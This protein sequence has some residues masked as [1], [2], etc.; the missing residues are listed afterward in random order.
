MK[1]TIE[2]DF[3]RLENL[4]YELLDP[5]AALAELANEPKYTPAPVAQLSTQD[6]DNFDTLNFAVPSATFT[7]QVAKPDNPANWNEEFRHLEAS[8][9]NGCIWSFD[10]D[11]SEE[12]CLQTYRNLFNSAVD[13]LNQQK[14]SKST[15]EILAEFDSWVG[16]PLDVL[17]PYGDIDFN[18]NIYEDSFE[19]SVPVRIISQNE[20]IIVKA[21][22]PWVKANHF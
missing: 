7:N 3:K 4:G 18:H 22:M 14:P 6:L 21:N 15:E 16:T 12:V 19:V 20:E 10:E 1:D 8:L 2:M 17:S 9:S 13:L 11:Q 5:T